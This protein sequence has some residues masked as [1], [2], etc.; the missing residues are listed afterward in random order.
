MKTKNLQG[1]RAFTYVWGPEGYYVTEKHGFADVDSAKVYA[2]E[3]SKTGGAYE[4]SVCIPDKSYRQ[5]DRVRRVTSFVK[6]E[7]K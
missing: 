4:V 1:A 7:E 2:E 3:R 5:G 6:G